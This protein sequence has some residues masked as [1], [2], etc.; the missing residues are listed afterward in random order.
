LSSSHHPYHP[1]VRQQAFARLFLCFNARSP[2]LVTRSRADAEHGAE[3]SR[4]WRP[5]SESRKWQAQHLCRA[6]AA[7]DSARIHGGV[8]KRFIASSLRGI[9]IS[10][11]ATKRSMRAVAFRI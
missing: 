3:I 11:S 5:P 4:W 1:A 7:R 6:A 10:S 9:G 8:V 2:Q